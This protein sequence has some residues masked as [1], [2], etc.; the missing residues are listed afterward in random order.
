VTREKTI[1]PDSS[2]DIRAG[3]DQVRLYWDERARSSRP[4][5][6][7]LQWSH[8]RTQRLRFEAFLLDHDLAGR[9]VLDLGCGLGDF[10]SHL[11]ERGIAVEYLGYDIA[12]SMVQQCRARYPQQ[13]FESG[14]FLDYHPDARFDYSVAFG[15]HNIPTPGGRAILEQTTRHQFA[16][17]GIAAHLTLLSNRKAWFAPHLQAWPVEEI[18]AMALDITPHVALHHDYLPGDFSI[19]LYREVI[20]RSRLDALVEYGG[21]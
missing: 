2:N 5:L 1:V 6:E 20:G 12:P 10:Y 7:K 21:D 19:T 13:R 16:L 11:R 3:L 9:S 17:S 4:D 18:L 8:R 15:I 14:D